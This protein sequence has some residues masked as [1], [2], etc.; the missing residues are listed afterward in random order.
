MRT[1]DK[2]VHEAT[3]PIESTVATVRPC[4][5][6]AR[7]RTAALAMECKLVESAQQRWRAVNAPHLVHLVRAGAGF[8][9]GLPAGRSK[10][11]AA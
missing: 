11:T 10:A 5:R 1:N 7:S 9:R 3:G 2:R 8:E 6:G 4:T